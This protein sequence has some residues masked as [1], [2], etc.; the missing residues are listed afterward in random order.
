MPDTAKTTHV[1]KSSDKYLYNAHPYSYYTNTNSVCKQLFTDTDQ[2]LPEEKCFY[3]RRKR[4]RK[5]IKTPEKDLFS[6]DS[7]FNW[8]TPV[9]NLT[10]NCDNTKTSF[11]V[12]Q[13]CKE[14]YLCDG[15]ANDDSSNDSSVIIESTIS[16]SH[17]TEDNI[18][19]VSRTSAKKYPYGQ[20]K[21]LTFSVTVHY[22]FTWAARFYQ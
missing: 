6:F 3:K 8:I 11:I 16:S 14:N 22:N 10:Q 9:E 18:G 1:N 15:I 5:I 17:R 13:E 2:D 19:T 12:S 4:K 21:H 7:Y 20:L